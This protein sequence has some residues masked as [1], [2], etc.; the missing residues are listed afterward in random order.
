MP[1]FA[2]SANAV[3]SVR[4]QADRPTTEAPATVRLKPD[5]TTGDA[6]LHLEMQLRAER[7]DARLLRLRRLTERRSVV[8]R[9]GQDRV[10]VERVEEVGLNLPRASAVGQLEL[11][12]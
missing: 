11:A 1:T 2:L 12:R 9:N 8:G 10:R 7:E 3:R 6:S 4:L 5:T